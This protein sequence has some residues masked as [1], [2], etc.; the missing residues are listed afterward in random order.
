MKILYNFPVNELESFSGPLLEKDLD[1][2][3]PVEYEVLFFYV[4]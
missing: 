3:K 2:P 1:F 4:L